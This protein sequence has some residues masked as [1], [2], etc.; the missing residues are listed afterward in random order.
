MTYRTDTELFMKKAELL[1]V[2]GHPQRLCIVKVLC[3]KKEVTVSD[4]QE[5]LDEVQPMVSQHL[6][7]LKAARIIEGRRVGTNIYYSIC[8]EEMK[9]QVQRIINNLFN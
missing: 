3:E 1:K 8:N 4:M 7:K 6:S 5:C 2:L 9:L